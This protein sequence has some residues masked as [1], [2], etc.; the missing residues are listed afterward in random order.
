[1][2]TITIERPLTDEEKEFL[3]NFIQDT[4]YTDDDDNTKIGFF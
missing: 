1:M 4:E 3:T 2:I